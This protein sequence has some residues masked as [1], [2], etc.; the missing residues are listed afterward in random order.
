M[1]CPRCGAEMDPKPRRRRLWAQ[2]RPDDI[3]VHFCPVCAKFY[4]VVP[5]W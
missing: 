3:T 1:K 5:K 4:V 2:Y